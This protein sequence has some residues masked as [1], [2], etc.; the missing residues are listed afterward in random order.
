PPVISAFNFD[1]NL[2]EGQRASITCNV[3]SGDLPIDIV[4]LKDF[5]SIP[6][7]LNITKERVK[8]LSYL[9]FEELRNEHSGVYTC[10]ASNAAATA[11]Y[12][13]TLTVKVP[14]KWIHEPQDGRVIL[15]SDHVLACEAS[16]VPKPSIKWYREVGVMKSEIKTDRKFELGEDGSC[17]VRNVESTDAGSYTCDAINGVGNGLS[18]S[19]RLDVN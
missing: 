3:M 18:K 6:S 4:W 17:R 13:A 12:S 7:F 9:I 15:R 8:F 16:G 5:Q 19:I 10:S 14:P 2:V 11:N 1:E